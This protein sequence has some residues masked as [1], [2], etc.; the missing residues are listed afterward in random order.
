MPSWV[1]PYKIR[2][3]S[4]ILSFGVRQNHTGLETMGEACYLLKRKERSVS[5]R[6]FEDRKVSTITKTASGYEVDPD[7][8]AFR[9]PLW[10]EGEDSRDEYPDIYTVTA[11]VQATGDGVVWEPSLDKYSFISGR[12][13]YAFDIFRN[14]IDSDG[15]SIDD[16]VYV[17]FN[18]PPFDSSATVVFNFGTISPATD[19]ER[20]QPDVEDEPGF[21]NS[22]FSYD[23][24]LDLD[25]FIRMR[26]TPHQFLLAFPGT[27]TD[28]IISDGG[29]VQDARASYW[30]TP[31]NYSPKV[32]EWD[33]VVRVATGER[34]QVINYTPIYVE[35]VLASQ[36]FD[37]AQL[38]PRSAAYQIPIVTS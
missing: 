22:L 32:H 37:L 19:F 29:F 15:N 30:T 23:Q 14:Q 3:N 34:Y 4:N 28:F 27:A 18:T 13:E 17:V 20:M 16:A 21:Y 7:T 8:G 31:P 33:I 1:R 2:R 10:Q 36:H 9:Y 6:H 25:A 24:W 26:Q 11:T 38:D 35:D 5:T 12:K